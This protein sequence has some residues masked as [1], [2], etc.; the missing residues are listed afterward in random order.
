[1]RVFIQRSKEASVTID[2]EIHGQIEKGM[3]VLVGFK[4]G[5]QEEWIDKMVD[6]MIHLRIYS[7]ENDKMNLSLLDV[8]GQV[9]SISQFTLYANTRHGRRPSFVEAEKPARASWLYDMFN[10]ALRKRGI[11]VEQ[12]IFGAN[13]QVNLI[14]DGPVT[15]LLDSE[16]FKEG[17]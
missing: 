6:K 14:N 8:G 11:Q 3:V 13:M 2:G 5:D 17:K 9:L 15:I 7:D 1:M 10:H 12:G 4:E 16:D